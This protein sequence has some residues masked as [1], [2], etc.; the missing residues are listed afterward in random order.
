MTKLTNKEFLAT[1]M[2]NVIAGLIGGLVVFALF[3]S[4]VALW[5]RLGFL[6]VVIIILW[7]VALF[8]HHYFLK[9]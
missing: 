3:Q 7:F 5:R 6:I 2:L 1:F 8:F 9:K 4:E